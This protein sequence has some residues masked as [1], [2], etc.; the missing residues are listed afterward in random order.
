MD[1]YTLL[2][3]AAGL[4]ALLT[5]A[6]IPSLKAKLK[7]YSAF[8]RIRNAAT[9]TLAEQLRDLSGVCA[10]SCLL[11]L[12]ALWT[13]QL[14]GYSA[15]DLLHKASPFLTGVQ[16]RLSDFGE[17]WKVWL[18]ITLIGSLLLVWN[19]RARCFEL[20]PVAHL[21]GAEPVIET[22]KRKPR[23]LGAVAADEGNR[24]DRLLDQPGNRGI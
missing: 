4:W 16:Q 11:L 22:A 6:V 14:A 2:V 1:L 9:T 24:R 18:F 3:I 17:F 15:P 12:L 23:G 20:H 10:I 8:Q 7:R 21:R 19:W 13:L 5:F